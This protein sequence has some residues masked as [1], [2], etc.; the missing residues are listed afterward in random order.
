MK[1]LKCIQLL[2]F[3]VIHYVATDNETV[4]YGCCRNKTKI[5]GIG[6]GTHGRGLERLL[7]ARFSCKKGRMIQRVEPRAQILEPKTT[8]NTVKN[9]SQAIGLSSNQHT[10]VGFHIGSAAYHPCSL[11]EGE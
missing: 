1:E 3:G 11:F 5:C 7:L 10:L 4:W 2:S 8:V 9:E 6:F